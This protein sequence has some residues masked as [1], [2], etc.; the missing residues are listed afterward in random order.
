MNLNLYKKNYYFSAFLF[1]KRVDDFLFW[2]MPKTWVPLYNSVSFTHMPYKKCIENRAWQDRMLS[3]LINLS[4]F[5]AV[6][7]TGFGIFM[8][9]KNFEFYYDQISKLF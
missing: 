3:R 7:L 6:G 2:M 9:K 8:I 5:A 4:G 1:R